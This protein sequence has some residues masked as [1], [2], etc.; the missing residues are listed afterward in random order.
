MSSRR[1]TCTLIALPV[2]IAVTA[3]AAA[4]FRAVV[5]ALGDVGQQRHFSRA[6]DR[7]RDLPLVPPAG[8]GDP[9]RADLPLLGDVAAQLVGVLPVDLHNLVPAEPAV[10]LP[11]RA[12][13]GAAAGAEVCVLR[14]SGRP[15]R[16][17]LRLAALALAAAAEELNAVSDDLDRLALRPVLGV[18]LAP[19]EPAVDRDR[20]ALGQVLGAILTLVAPDRDVEVVRLLR[21]LAGGA[22][23]AARVDGEPEAADRGTAR[24]VPELWVARQI[25]Q[26]NDS[27][28][29][30]GHLKPPHPTGVAWSSESCLCSALLSSVRAGPVTAI[31]LTARWRMTPSVILRTRETSARASG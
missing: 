16:H 24:R 1:I 11:D 29:V 30:G 26:E 2:S 18:P 10:L 8:A 22:V 28:D 5:P 12:G 27:V 3:V 25:A 21:P 14:L 13:G 31:R 23:L 6:L 19:F 17:E 9:A 15:G 4:A 20:A 7:D